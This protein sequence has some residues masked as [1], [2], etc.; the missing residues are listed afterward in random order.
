MGYRA[1]R[2]QQ[3]SRDPRVIAALARLDRGQ[4]E[5]VAAAA[6]DLLDRLDGDPDY[7]DSDNDHSL[8]GCEPRFGLDQ[9]A[10]ELPSRLQCRALG[11]SYV[12][13]WIDPLK[14]RENVERLARE[15][16]V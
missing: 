11:T 9:T 12:E 3:L 1:D 5:T 7:E 2:V 16:V 14:Q 8:G 10:G 13:R 15:G 6:I 4:L